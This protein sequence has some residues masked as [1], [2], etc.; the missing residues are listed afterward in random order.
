[1]D[2]LARSASHTKYARGWFLT[3]RLREWLGAAPI[4]VYVLR[5][6]RYTAAQYAIGH[7][8]GADYGAFLQ[9]TQEWAA[10]LNP[11]EAQDYL[12]NLHVVAN[13]EHVTH[14]N[15]GLAVSMISAAISHLAARLVRAA[16]PD[17]LSAKGCLLP[18]SP[19]SNSAEPGNTATL[20]SCVAR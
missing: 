5:L 17:D 11:T 7:A 2:L 19:F 12:W 15:F 13:M 3:A 20:R 18:A 4:D 9:S 6:A 1:M 16:P 10:N 14:R 8:K